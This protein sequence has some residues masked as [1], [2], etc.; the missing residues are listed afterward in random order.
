[1]P[2]RWSIDHGR[3]RVSAVLLETTTEQEM[4]DFLGEV[5]GQ[6]AMPY[7]KVFDATG[8][9]KWISPG[10]IGPIAATARLY[11]RMKLGPIGPLAIVVSGSAATERAHEYTLL[12]DAARK[13]RLFNRVADAEAWLAS[14][15]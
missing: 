10:R 5:I 8:A 15:S 11:S 6:D 3:K 7:G 12:S 4:Y 9:I 1:M 13:V 2:L 14:G